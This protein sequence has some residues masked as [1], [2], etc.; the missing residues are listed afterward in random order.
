MEDAE[1]SIASPRLMD[2]SLEETFEEDQE[3]PPAQCLKCSATNFGSYLYGFVFPDEDLLAQTNRGEI[4]LAG[5]C[6]EFDSPQ[7]FCRSCNTDQL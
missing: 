2:L 4:R 6:F 7:W 5:C 1:E 3:N